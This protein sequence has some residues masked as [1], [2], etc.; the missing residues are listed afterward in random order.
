MIGRFVTNTRRRFLFPKFGIHAILQIMMIEMPNRAEMLLRACR[1]KVRGRRE[2][3]DGAVAGE[4]GTFAPQ[5]SELMPGSYF[6]QTVLMLHN[7]PTLRHR[8]T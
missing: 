4:L 1:A 2:P 6:S 7:E 5:K 8:A 3:S